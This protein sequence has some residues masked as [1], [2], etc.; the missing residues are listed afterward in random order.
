MSD[1]TKGTEVATTGEPSQTG[2]SIDVMFQ[3]ILEAV[4]DPSVDPAKARELLA[5][6]TDM[7]DRVAQQQFFAAMHRAVSGM[8]TIAKNGAILNKSG[9]VQSRYST[10]E[11][12]DAIVRPIANAEGLAYT[13]DIGESDRGLLT[14]SMLVMHTGGGSKTY[15]PMPVPAD[16]SGS[17]NATQGAGS[18]TAYGKRYVLCAGF[19]IITSGQDTDGVTTAVTSDGMEYLRDEG[20]KAAAKG[21]KQ[22][23]IWSRKLTN[24]E[25]G[26]L[27]DQNLVQALKD[28][29]ADIDKLSTSKD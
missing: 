15:G 26:W 18:S 17:K 9:Q 14:V 22:L 3:S 4:K 13:F 27:V 5:I 12:I 8:P 19:N 16:T 6:Q 25:R 23:G 2:M 10:F 11:A 29:A 21:S 28:A 7:M 1:D 24:A 20:Q